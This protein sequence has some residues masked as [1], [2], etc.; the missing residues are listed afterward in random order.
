MKT[1]FGILGFAIVVCVLVGLVV[2]SWWFYDVQQ[3]RKHVVTVE[4]QTTV[5]AGSGTRLCRGQ[6]LTDLQTGAILPVRRIRYWKNC[7]TV[8]VILRDGRHGYIVLGE[9]GVTVSPP[10]PRI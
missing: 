4:S 8:D 9:G 5:F 1:L 7:A 2:A 3:D 6:R 10:L